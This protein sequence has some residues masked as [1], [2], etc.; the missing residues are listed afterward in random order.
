MHDRVALNIAA[1]TATRHFTRLPSVPSRFTTP[2]SPNRR[3]HSPH[4]HAARQG[5]RNVKQSCR[6]AV[7]FLFSKTA[8]TLNLWLIPGHGRGGASKPLKANCCREQIMLSLHIHVMM[9]RDSSYC[10]V[11]TLSTTE[12]L[13]GNHYFEGACG[14]PSRRLRPAT[15]ALPGCNDSHRSAC[16]VRGMANAFDP[17]WSSYFARRRAVDASD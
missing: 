6:R 4:R 8:L 1:V 9:N 5:L 10:R 12:A 11:S 14:D 3:T 15:S 2:C 17:Q 13:R 7:T 16:Q